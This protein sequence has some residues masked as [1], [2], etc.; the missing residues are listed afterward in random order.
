MFQYSKKVKNNIIS[1]LIPMAIQYA[2]KVRSSISFFCGMFMCF[3]ALET[4]AEWLQDHQ[5]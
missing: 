1:E 4:V 5:H 2:G 3:A